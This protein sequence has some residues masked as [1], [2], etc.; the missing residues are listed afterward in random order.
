MRRTPLKAFRS[1][2]LL[3][4]RGIPVCPPSPLQRNW[5]LPPADCGDRIGR[6]SR[7]AEQVTNGGKC[8]RGVRRAH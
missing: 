6:L 8:F 1:A 2:V 5:R 3:R 7:I 4:R